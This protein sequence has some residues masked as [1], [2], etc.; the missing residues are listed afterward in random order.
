MHVVELLPLELIR[1]IPEHPGVVLD[2]GAETVLAVVVDV[3]L[4]K[5]AASDGVTRDVGRCH[6]CDVDS[7]LVYLDAFTQEIVA[8]MAAVHDEFHG[9]PAWCPLKARAPCGLECEVVAQRGA[10]QRIGQ[11]H[12]TFVGRHAKHLAFLSKLEAIRFLGPQHPRGVASPL[13]VGGAFEV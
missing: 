2:L 4:H 6:L 5:I 12:P 1:W 13:D 3:N 7:V 8:H 10:V 11:Q 9:L